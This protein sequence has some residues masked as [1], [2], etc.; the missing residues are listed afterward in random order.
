MLICVVPRFPFRITRGRARWPLGDRWASQ[1]LAAPK[2]T[3]QFRN[4]LTAEVLHLTG[5][6]LLSD[7][8]AHFPVAVLVRE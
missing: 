6:P 8:F 5:A 7:I 1:A 4:V 3:G 2:L